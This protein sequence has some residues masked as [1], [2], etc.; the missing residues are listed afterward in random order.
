MIKISSDICNLIHF[1]LN[2]TLK[3]TTRFSSPKLCP[4][5]SRWWI[6]CTA[7]VHQPRMF[8]INTRTARRQRSGK[9]LSAIS[10][11]AR[12][13]TGT[14][15]WVCYNVRDAAEYWMLPAAPASIPWCC[16]K[17]ASRS[18]AS[19]LLTRCSSTR[20]NTDGIAGRSLPLTIGVSKLKQ[21]LGKIEQ[22]DNKIK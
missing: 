19:M 15:W 10:S 4:K 20:W 13:T 11:S 5:V 6:P 16:S 21:I 2:Y 14:S 7:L 8:R 3:Y 18:S 1:Y 17:R 9:S 22:K 12:R